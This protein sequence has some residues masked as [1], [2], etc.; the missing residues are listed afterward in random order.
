[1]AVKVTKI[2]IPKD[3]EY[4]VIGNALGLMI[5]VGGLLAGNMM[6]EQS[7]EYWR[8]DIIPL[9]ITFFLAYRLM[10]NLLLMMTAYQSSSAPPNSV[11]KEDIQRIHAS[12][13]QLPDGG[14]S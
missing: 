5:A 6:R 11:S 9:A 10:R 12:V 14:A 3:I 7:F 13:A 2:K 4:R 1:M 8:G